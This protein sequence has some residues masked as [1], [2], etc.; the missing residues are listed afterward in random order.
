MSLTIYLIR[1]CQPSKVDFEYIDHVRDQ[2]LTPLGEKQAECIADQLT[3]WN[4]EQLY[5]SS[6][7]RSVQTAKIIQSKLHIPWH[8]WPDLAETNR[9]KWMKL[10]DEHIAA[11]KELSYEESSKEP[12]SSP[13]E[14]IK[15]KYPTIQLS[16]PFDLTHKWWSPSHVES[17]EDTYE[18][19]R[20]VIDSLLRIHAEGDQCI[21]V[22][23]H[24]AFAS[25]LLTIFTNGLPCDHNR[26][27]Y[28]HGAIARIDV[29]SASDLAG[30]AIPIISLNLINY[31]GHFKEE[32]VTG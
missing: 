32:L 26:F 29:T 2:R 14:L 27:T 15:Q 8:L 20:R 18:R 3:T 22:V 13:I 11:V 16:Q 12:S 25:V 5:C 17:R 21:G 30:Y 1:H 23:C 6:M 28:H 9:H 31:I 10:R 4:I 24:A 19:G 7:T